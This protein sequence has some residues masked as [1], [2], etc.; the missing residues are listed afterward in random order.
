MILSLYMLLFSVNSEPYQ[1]SNRP[2]ESFEECA[3]FVNLLAK[4]DVVMPDGHFLFMTA[5]YW[6]FKGECVSTKDY[7]KRSYDKKQ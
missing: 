3:S 2:F 7:M 1:I 5:D 4:R 6:V